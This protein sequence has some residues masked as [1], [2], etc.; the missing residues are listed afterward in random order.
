MTDIKIRYKKRWIRMLCVIMTS[1]LLT[2]N[3]DI[4]GVNA[5]SKYMTVEEFI[6]AIKAEF[7]DVTIKTKLN[8][9]KTLTVGDAAILLVKAAYAMGEEKIPENTVEFI[10]ENRLK[11]QGKTSDTRRK[12]LARAFALGLVKGAKVEEFSEVRSFRINQKC[13]KSRCKSMISRLKDK[14]KR[15]RLSPDW[16]LL[17]TGKKN[18]PVLEDMYEYILEDYPNDY[19]DTMFNFMIAQAVPGNA[20]QNRLWKE[21]GCDVYLRK[22]TW[23]TTF[24]KLTL[25]DR[26]NFLKNY[27]S[28]DRL[29]IYSAYILPCEYDDFAANYSKATGCLSMPLNAS[30]KRA[31]AD[32]AEEYAMYAMNVDYR[33][34][35]SDSHW[36]SYML[37]NGVTREAVDEYIAACIRD[38][39]IIECDCTAADISGIYY[40]RSPFTFK[41]SEGVVRTYARYRVLSDNGSEFPDGNLIIP[42]GSGRQCLRNTRI[43]DDGTVYEWVD[44]DEWQ[45]GYFDIGVD[46]DGRINAAVFDIVRFKGVFIGAFGY[47]CETPC[48][49]PGTLTVDGILATRMKNM[50]KEKYLAEW[51]Y[52]Y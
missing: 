13:S 49:Y 31:M 12:Y 33:T 4:V 19:Y 6:D 11:I 8:P 48:Y 26:M 27:D 24:S 44:T 3:A 30:A 22:M 50:T 34:I 51:G 29:G 47:P 14:S 43:S 2:S 17:R 45:D 37:D 52:L 38:E 40:D 20:V 21:R 7:D 46:A 35:S 9:G 15:Y 5:D 16:R 25:D 36:R 41:S 28:S 23:D 39:L 1:V 32:A 18:M 42:N 10:A